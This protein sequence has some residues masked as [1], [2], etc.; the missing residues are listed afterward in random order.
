[1]LHSQFGDSG[2]LIGC[3]E[4]SWWSSVFVAKSQPRQGGSVHATPN[5]HFIG[6]FEP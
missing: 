3:F 2:M 4:L 6:G 5:D 1:M